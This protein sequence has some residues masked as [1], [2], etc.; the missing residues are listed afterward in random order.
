MRWIDVV[1]AADGNFSSDGL[2]FLII[3]VSEQLPP[4]REP[5]LTTKSK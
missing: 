4:L 2:C 3:Q 5:S 1:V